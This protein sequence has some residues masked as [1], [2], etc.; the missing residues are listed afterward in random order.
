MRLDFCNGLPKETCTNV[1]PSS[2]IVR[3]YGGQDCHVNG[4]LECNVKIGDQEKVVRFLIVPVP[5]IDAKILIGVDTLET[6][7]YR[8]INGK[9]EVVKEES[10]E[11]N[12]SVWVRR[13][14]C[15]DSEELNVPP[16]Y[17][18]KVQAMVQS[19]KPG[20]VGGA[21]DKMK[22]RP[23]STQQAAR[24]CE[25]EYEIRIMCQE[26]QI[27]Q[28]ADACVFTTM[29]LKNSYF[30]VEMEEESRQYTGFITHKGQYEFMRA[31]FGLCT[32]GSAFGRF[33]GDVFREMIEAGIMLT[34]VDD[35]IRK[36]KAGL[37]FN[38][39]KCV[40]LQRR[41][42][43]LGYIIAEGYMQPAAQ[44][45]EKLR[46]FPKPRTTMQLQR[47]YG[48]ANYFRKFI[49]GFSC[50]AKPLS[51]L[52]KKSCEFRFGEKQAQVFEK[53]KELLTTDPVLMIF[54]AGRRTEVHTDASK[55]AL[56][57]ILMQYVEGS[58]SLALFDHSATLE[59]TLL[60]RI[61]PTESQLVSHP[62]LGIY[63][64]EAETEIHT[65]ALELLLTRDELWKYVEPRKKPADDKTR[66][67]I[68]ATPRQGTRS[69]CWL[70]II[71]TH[72][73]AKQKQPTRRAKS[74]R[75]IQPNV[76][77]VTPESV[78]DKRFT[79]GEDMA[80]FLFEM[81][82]LFNRLANAGQKL[83]EN[84]RVAMILRSLPS[85]Y[86]TLTT[87]LESRSDDDL[88]L[89]QGKDRPSPHILK[90]VVPDKP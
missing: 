42:E 62:V 2:R 40:F 74:S 59:S 66:L 67:G 61:R 15:G 1:K 84:L 88:T 75:K 73:S 4:E 11:G 52:F 19:Y 70:K 3:G 39:K 22:R 36:E 47:F 5:A 68:R 21:S 25:D 51:E 34:F 80:E 24:K 18:S 85:S 16:R 41:V 26:D 55:D 54:K 63:D 45:I 69:A 14:E 8:L 12:E 37:V 65:D 6:L 76:E 71:N 64:A 33:I 10:A 81:E 7:N 77:S 44:K 56:A 50:V 35:I 27:D 78:C 28:L 46:N 30:H 32:S 23:K 87:A 13:L 57:G 17:R 53:I 60:E 48:L 82:D 49:P 79:E 86:D 38:W 58:Q 20:A 43:Y 72:S 90:N 9:F 29:D 83:A 89:E 31:P